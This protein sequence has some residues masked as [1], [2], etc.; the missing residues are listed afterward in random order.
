MYNADSMT[1]TQCTNYDDITTEGV[2]WTSV[3]D[4][5]KTN[6]KT[7]QDLCKG[8]SN[9]GIGTNLKNRLSDISSIPAYFKW[10]RTNTTEFRGSNLFDFVTSSTA[11]ADPNDPVSSEFMLWIEIWGDQVPIGY[12][13]GPVTAVD[14]FGISFDVYE[15]QN[16]GTGVT[17]RSLLPTG[18]FKGAFQ[19]DLKDWLSAMV[20]QGYIK[21][22]DF[23][24]VGNAGAEIFY[25][26]SVMDA[27]VSLKVE[28]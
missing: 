1:G 17:V 16:P 15:G 13:R 6:D 24:N 11:G 18:S 22:S 12:S 19:G 28:V 23:V 25:G 14:L 27:T 8:Y 21:D 20:G 26:N 10:S 7:T 3:T 5:E 9:I 2:V 4:I